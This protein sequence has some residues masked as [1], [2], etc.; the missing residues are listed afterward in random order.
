M[1][2]GHLPLIGHWVIQPASQRLGQ[3]IDELW[4]D[5]GCDVD[6]SRHIDGKGRDRTGKDSLWRL[7]GVERAR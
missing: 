1:P 7:A 4:Q 6:K 5:I 3:E 2:T